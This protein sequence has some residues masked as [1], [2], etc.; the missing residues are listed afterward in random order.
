MRTPRTIAAALAAAA[1][2]GG[3]GG[4]AVMAAAGDSTTTVTTRVAAARPAGSSEPVAATSSTA[5]TPRQV[6]DAAKGSVAY[7]TS[8]ITE[9]STSPWGDT[10]SG[11]ATGSGFVVSADGYVVTN[12]HVVDGASKVTVKVGDRAAKTAKVVGIDDST[13]VALLKIDTGG[14]ALTPLELGD[15][16][17]VAVGDPVYAIGNPYGLSR[18]LT[19]GVV[20]ALQREIQSP[21]GW[22]ISNVIQT[23][24]ALNPGNSGGPLFDDAGKVIGIN[25]QI[26]TSTGSSESGNSGIGFAVPIDTVRSVIAQ[27]KATGHA[28]HAYLGVSASDATDGAGARIASVRS[29]SPAS[30]AGIR[31]GDT[32]VSIG[33]KAIADSA[34]LS[35]A[36]NAHRP[37]DDVAVVLQRGGERKQV[38]VKLDDQPAS[39]APD[40]AQGGFGPQQDPYLP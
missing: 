18:T 12:A 21:T 34:A 15:S 38:T 36:I 20:S 3:A 6:Y 7:I 19:T 29:S 35:A 25:S 2:A 17:A 1:L 27:L 10:Q 22:S 24:A 23:D 30:D 33:G 5:L 13:D 4:A 26:E 14:D 9:Q 11:E 39:A 32:I 8:Q 28:K 31:A 16:G 40:G 37:G